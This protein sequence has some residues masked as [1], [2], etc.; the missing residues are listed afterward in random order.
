MRHALSGARFVTCVCSV[1]GINRERNIWAK[2]VW[3]HRQVL[4]ERKYIILKQRGIDK[5]CHS[6]RSPTSSSKLLGLCRN[7]VFGL[8]HVWAGFNAFDYSPSAGSLLVC[9]PQIIP[10]KTNSTLTIED[11]GIGM[12]KNDPRPCKEWYCNGC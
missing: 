1:N 5:L 8:L 7:R 9:A 11:S 12:T 4:R 2:T 3:P 6:R 10:D